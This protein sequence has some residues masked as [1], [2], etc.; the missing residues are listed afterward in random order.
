MV[1]GYTVNLFSLLDFYFS[2]WIGGVIWRSYMCLTCTDDQGQSIYKILI[3]LYF[4]N[5]NRENISNIYFL[6]SN[7]LTSVPH[8][9]KSVK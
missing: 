9:L 7:K 6:C 3:K 4:L 5:K 1:E 2:L 8:F